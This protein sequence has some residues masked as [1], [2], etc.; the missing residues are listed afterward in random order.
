[1]MQTDRT[2]LLRHMSKNISGSDAG[3]ILAT[4]SFH[5]I[6][7]VMVFTASAPVCSLDMVLVGN[8][9]HSPHPIVVMI[10]M[11]APHLLYHGKVGL[12]VPAA[13][14]Y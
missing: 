13:A 12:E 10:P 4:Y 1:M 6:V 11:T 2:C 8:Y 14:H 5:G 3:I 9:H 7:H